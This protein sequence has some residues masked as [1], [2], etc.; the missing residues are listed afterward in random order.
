MTS[1]IIGIDVG[2]TNTD[3]A[4]LC[5]AEVVALLK[6][7]T[8]HADL[9]Q[10]TGEALQKI[11]EHHHGPEPVTLHLSTTLQTNTIVEGKGAKTMAVV[12]PGPGVNLASLDLPFPLIELSGSV[13]HR[14]REVAPLD[15]DQVRQLKDVLE[16]VEAL[17]IVGKFSQRNPCQEVTLASELS[18]WFKGHLSLGHRLSGRA[19]FPRR[20]ITACLNASIAQKQLEFLQIWEEAQETSVE[21]IAILKADGGTMTLAESAQRPVESILS[22]P[23][24]SI[25]GV[26]ALSQCAAQNYVII[27]IGGT[28][29]DLAAVVA[30]EVLY[31]RDGATIGGYKTL[32]PAVLARSIGLGGDSELAYEPER[33]ITIGPRRAGT[34]VCL[35]GDALTPTDAVVAQ[36][37]VELGSKEKAQVAWAAWA[38]G[39]DI[40]P[41]HLIQSVL[42][43]FTQSLCE[44]VEAFYQELEAIPLYTVEEVMH[45]PR[46]RP[47]AVVG[48]G[49]P[50]GVFLP[51][52]A[53]ALQLPWEVL[54]LSAGANAIGAA[55]ARSTVGVT[56]HADT[57]LGTI[58]IP[59]MGYQGSM[60]RNLF[61]DLPK[62]RQLGEEKTREYARSLGHDA[63]GEV[64]IV[65][66]ESFRMVRGFRTVGQRH[67]VRTQLRPDVRQI[68][69]GREQ[70]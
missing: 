36:G 22:G 13:D 38:K 30:G 18:P 46:L 68:R 62:A 33:G 28:T 23:A 47:D 3:A 31:E 4:L 2:G 50:A 65:E 39:L 41:E 14:G 24:A 29:T 9:L 5:G 27:D 53:S 54:P 43:A 15:L 48:L 35:G 34:P 42:H 1:Y 6:V 55:A 25:M 8:N 37:L 60:E 57:E 7:P 26:K 44:A 17:A 56:L 61:F 52:L 10:S 20:I 63:T 66:E 40:S 51:P 69:V 59:E 70:M 64:E 67:L 32:V 12:V 21:K 16:E 11:L 58:T 19:N 45:P 49:A